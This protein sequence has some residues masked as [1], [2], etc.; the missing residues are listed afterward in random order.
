MTQI[1]QTWFET[2]RGDPPR[3]VWRHSLNHALGAQAFC[4]ESG[5][6]FVADVRGG[7]YAINRSG[8]FSATART[9]GQFRG[10]AW[11]DDGSTGFALSG[12]RELYWLRADLSLRATIE[13]PEPSLAVACEAYGQYAAVS[14]SNATTLLFD[15]PQQPLATFSS[16]RPLTHLAFLC[17]ETGL[18]AIGDYGLICRY[19]L[20]G[21]MLW[22][23]N[24]FSSVGDFAVA[25][26]DSS[27]LV[28]GYGQGLLR[29]ADDGESIGSYQLGG[30]V[31]RVACSF[32]GNR[33]AAATQELELFWLGH[34]GQI[35]W[36]ARIP[37]VPLFLACD[38]W[39]IGL[40]CAFPGGNIIRLEW[41][42]GD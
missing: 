11:S 2:C 28:A 7:M 8:E 5:H 23:S 10:L 29:Y 38:P 24:T 9:A 27:L 30:T 16:T 14:L 34:G 35:L 3:V 4:R 13:L 22:Q 31:C 26:S 19:D 20:R 12:E 37:E 40:V 21:Q 6:L 39:G 17:Q 15:G 18:T 1:E 33:I 36:T 25:E 42:S 32:N 41:S